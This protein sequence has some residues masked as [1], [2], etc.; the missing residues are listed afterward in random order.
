[1]SCSAS[2]A[3]TGTYIRVLCHKIGEELGVGAHMA[4]LRR[5]QVNALHRTG[6][7]HHA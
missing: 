6:Q 4:E 2:N 7:S 1:M 5:T 3:S